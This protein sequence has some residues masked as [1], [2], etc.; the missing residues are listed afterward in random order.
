MNDFAPLRARF[1]PFQIDEPEGRLTRDGMRVELSPRAL[2]VLCELVRRP[3]QLVPD[4]IL[5]DRVWGHRHVSESVVRTV[6]SHL[7]QALGD[8]PRNPRYVETATRR[9]YRFVA[10]VRLDGGLPPPAYAQPVAAAVAAHVP[11]K[12]STLVGRETPSRLL[13]EAWQRAAGGS[14]QL[15]F[16]C[17]E[18]GIGKSAL[19]DDF[20]ATLPDGTAVARSQCV[21]HYGPAEPYMPLLEALNALCRTGI[22]PTLRQRLPVVAPTWLLQMPWLMGAEDRRALRQEAGAAT[23]DRMLRELGE[24]LDRSGDAAP[25][26]VVFEDLHWSDHAT[27]QALAFIAHR[28]TASALLIIGTFRPTELIIQQHPL[29]SLRHE[30]KM[31]RLCQE[32]ALEPLSQRDLGEWLEHQFHARAP[33]AFTQALHDLTSGL[34]LFATHVI[35]EWIA[36][37]AMGAAEDAFALQSSCER[38]VPGSIVQTIEQH[39]ARLTPGEQRM[40]GAAS[41]G[42]AEFSSLCLAEVLGR[43]PTEIA[44]ELE[45]LAGRVSWLRAAE[46]QA[47]RDGRIDMRYAFR[48]SLYRQAIAQSLPMSQSIPWHKAWAAALE[49]HHEGDGSELA[50]QIALHLERGREP[51][52]AA[53]RLV[54]VA[55]RAIERGAP[56]EAI[57]AARHGLALLAN[58]PDRACEQ[59]LRVL[60]AVALTRTHVVSTPEVADAFARTSAL[61]DIASPARLRAVH[62]RWWVC[63]SRGQFG[64]ARRIAGDIRRQADESGDPLAAAIGQCSMGMT[65]A[66]EGDLAGARA[67]LAP[68][69]AMQVGD[70]SDTPMGPF[71]QEPAVDGG[72]TLALLGWIAGD[73]SAARAQARDAIDLAVALRHPLS[74]VSALYLAAAVHALAGEFEAVDALVGR[75]HA[76]I[77]THA[78]STTSSGFDWLRGR[79]RVAQGHV[80]EGL[81]LMRGAAASATRCGLLVTLDGFHCHHAEA[82]LVAGRPDLAE[83]SAREGLALAESAGMRLLESALWRQLALSLQAQ[84]DAPGA[85]AAG[86]RA[87]AV[88]RTQG[89][90]FFEIQARA[91]AFAHGWPVDEPGR[92]AALL[93]TGCGD[94][95]PLLEVIRAQV[96]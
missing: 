46:V 90:A 79:A 70:R 59:V 10:E 81:A 78:L 11:E 47:R 61:D 14:R 3:N 2:A 22:G 19:V 34:P 49:R 27:V 36:S 7:R 32:I 94:P 95:S 20:L 21:E 30:F 44:G 92:L 84:G 35:E 82:C 71:V 83:A 64:P 51:V 50:A 77:E 12:A 57:R 52:A 76:V 54:D 28:R 17:G 41:V 87:V 86:L 15:V 63:F 5:L 4:A 53:A 8:D 9:G 60:E 91:A 65:L 66:M 25:V 48:H 62:G 40:L 33:D 26:V 68:V 93:D 85:Q 13:R 23:Q 38:V 43:D 89:A 42:G 96:A 80:D 58:A 37:G 39:V 29:A 67:E 56:G 72:A 1:G 88:A 69:V 18:A 6:V 45:I 55:G 16:V 75:L 24:L 31:R 73:F 74:E